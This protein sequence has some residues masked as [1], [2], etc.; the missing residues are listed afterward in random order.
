MNIPL[1]GLTEYLDTTNFYFDS[2][3]GGAFF[4]NPVVTSLFC[5]FNENDALELTSLWFGKMTSEYEEEMVVND[6]AIEAVRKLILISKQ[7]QAQDL[8][9]VHIWF[10]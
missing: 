1:F 6:D 7:A 10:L 3:E 4:V 8:D 2:E 5:K 9:L